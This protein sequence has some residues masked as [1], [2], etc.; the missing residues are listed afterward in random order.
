MRI[1]LVQKPFAYVGRNYKLRHP[2]SSSLASGARICHLCRGKS[3]N[4]IVGPTRMSTNER[5][6]DVAVAIV[7]YRSAKLTIAC[8]R[9]I[10]LERLRCGMRIR[11]IVVD[12]ASGD[13]STILSALEA[14]GWHSWVT[15]IE[16][17]R[18]GGFAFGNNIAFRHASGGR[19]P[20]YLYMLNPDTEVRPGAIVSLVN[21]LE[22]HPE[23]GLA[24]SSFETQDG[25]D[26]PFAFRFPSILGEFE[27]GVQ[28]KFATWLLDRWV[29]GR[30]MTAKAQPTDWVSGASLMMRQRVFEEIGG[31][32][33]HYFLYF[34]ETDFC[35]RAKQAG[36]ATWYV[37]TSRVM[38]I[39]G[40]STQ[41]TGQAEHLRRLPSYWF[42]S[43]RR[44]FL[45]NHGLTYTIAADVAALLA[46]C[47]RL[48]KC[49]VQRRNNQSI[50]HYL[51][52]L[53]QH[54]AVWR[55]NRAPTA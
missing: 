25:R 55:R 14:H 1:D 34:E 48:C 37:P 6:I 21:F 46:H 19:P 27:H 9:S 5:E 51:H 53:W 42:E 3:S 17:S 44:Y 15:L 43:R 36:F 54:S 24:G 45:K 33:E 39:L 26:W 31:L 10:E 52:D 28:L 13:A 23:V 29:I 11:V 40:Q 4:P 35:F 50:P 20:Q 18:N 32:D 30:M 8:L 7:T 47:L 2:I 49:W 38:H 12:N 22:T 16:T 41:V